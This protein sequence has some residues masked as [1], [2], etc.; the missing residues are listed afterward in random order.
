MA[1]KIQMPNGTK[2]EAQNINDYTYGLTKDFAGVN[3]ER[4]TLPTGTGIKYKDPEK[5]P[6]ASNELFKKIDNDDPVIIQNAYGFP[7]KL[8]NYPYTYSYLQD[9]W[10]D[11]FDPSNSKSSTMAGDIA[12]IERSLNLDYLYEKGSRAQFFSQ[13]TRYYDKYKIG[14]PVDQLSKT[15]SHVFF[16]RP[17]CNIFKSDKYELVKDLYTIPEF[18]RAFKHSPELLRQLEQKTPPVHADSEMNDRGYPHQFMMFLSN[19]AASFDLTDEYITSDEYGKG[20]T[21]YK[22]AYGKHNV[23]SKTSN[24]FSVSYTDDRELHIYNLHKLWTNYISYVYRGKISP[25]TDYILNRILD[26]ATCVYYIVCAE[27]GETI[28]FWSKYWGVFPLDSPSSTFN[29]DQKTGGG[30]KSPE[31]K[32]QYHYSWKEDYNPLALVEFNQHSASRQSKYIHSY[33]EVKVGTGYTWSCAPFIETIEK[34]E[35]GTS[36]PYTFKLRFR[37]M[38]S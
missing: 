16:I 20:L 10:S 38:E 14:S 17:D 28:I 29:F 32:I 21:G 12:N 19:K 26:Y 11:K 37:P 6:N 1:N 24:K 33:N 30:V 15:F 35:F 25:K 9:Y 4:N 13:V 27:D 23:E 8:T 7:K 31:M 2:K 22:V 5:L 18:Y 34:K 36:F 3:Y